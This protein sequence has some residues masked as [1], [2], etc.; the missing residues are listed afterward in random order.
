MLV[1]MQSLA[2]AVR[3][4]WRRAA[5]AIGGPSARPRR[6]VPV[7]V[8]L[9]AV[10][11]AA[12]GAALATV[13]GKPAGVSVLSPGIPQTRPAPAKSAGPVVPMLGG[14]ADGAGKPIGVPVARA[15]AA[16]RT[17]TSHGQAFFRSR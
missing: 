9:L 13:G 12:T 3:R 15:P 17:R 16:A 2:D 5:H 14:N 4:L 10:A 6:L 7:I 1:L 8:S 11:G